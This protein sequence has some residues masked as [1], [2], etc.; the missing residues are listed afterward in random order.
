MKEKTPRPKGLKEVR[1]EWTPPDHLEVAFS[2]HPI[3]SSVICP[4]GKGQAKLQ[5]CSPYVA[6]YLGACAGGC[7]TDRAVSV[8]MSNIP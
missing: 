1:V 8:D 4:G 5:K 2:A 3:S 7:G 6:T